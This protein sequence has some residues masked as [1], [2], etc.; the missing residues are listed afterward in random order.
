MLLGELAEKGSVGKTETHGYTKQVAIE[1]GGYQGFGHGV[2][3]ATEYHVT[4]LDCIVDIVERGFQS[5]VL[6]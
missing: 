5:A 3:T 4:S 2:H 6:A 1:V